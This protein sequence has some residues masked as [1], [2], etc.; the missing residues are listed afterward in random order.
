M[1]GHSSL[2]HLSS[3]VIIMG[4][5]SLLSRRWLEICLLMGSSKYI[6]LF[7]LLVCTAFAFIKLPLP[8]PRN[9]CIFC[10]PVL[11]RRGSEGGL[12]EGS[13]LG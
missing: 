1:Q 5:E 4:A 13:Q 3:Q 2:Q 9:F 11:L 6:P 7:A 12:R 10:A 8:Q